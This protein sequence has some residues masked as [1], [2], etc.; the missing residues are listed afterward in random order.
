[1]AVVTRF[2]L[3]KNGF[4][5]I[6]KLLMSRASF[7]F[8]HLSRK[9]IQVALRPISDGANHSL[10]N[11]GVHGTLPFTALQ[12]IRPRTVMTSLRPVIAGALGYASESPGR[13]NIANR[14]H[15]ARSG[16]GARV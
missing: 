10:D 6:S 16:Y 12:T 13:E 3:A 14:H 5:L 9:S 2:G 11:V 15:F 8:N 4:Q 7:R 1:M